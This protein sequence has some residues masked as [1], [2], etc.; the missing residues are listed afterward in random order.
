MP[1][2]LAPR[3]G[4]SSALEIA[5]CSHQRLQAVRN[6]LRASE[7]EETFP[8]TPDTLQKDLPC[9][10]RLCPRSAPQSTCT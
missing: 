2:D 1:S 3:C 6:N 10:V 9:G 4:R 7:E 5:K 8:I